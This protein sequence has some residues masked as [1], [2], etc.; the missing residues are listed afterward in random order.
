MRTGEPHRSRDLSGRPGAV[1]EI[2]NTNFWRKSYQLRPGGGPARFQRP[3]RPEG[4]PPA[5]S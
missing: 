1:H 5:V 4:D 2:R 3:W